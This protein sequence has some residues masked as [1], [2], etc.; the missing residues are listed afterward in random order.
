[1]P[2]ARLERAS[3]AGA[4]RLGRPHRLSARR[5]IENARRRCR[6]SAPRTMLPSGFQNPRTLGANVRNLKPAGRAENSIRRNGGLA[7]RALGPDDTLTRLGFGS[8]RHLLKALGDSPILDLV[9]EG[10]VDLPRLGALTL[11]GQ[12]GASG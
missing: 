2:A 9:V 8:A 3:A 11:N 5:A 4:V 10:H 1:A 12:Y 7:L 6:V